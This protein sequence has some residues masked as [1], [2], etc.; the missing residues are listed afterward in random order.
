MKSRV[1]AI[2]FVLSLSQNCLADF[3][4]GVVAFIAG[5][6]ENALSMF[7]PLAETANH[8]YAQYFIGRMYA[9]GQ[10]VD[11][12][13]ELAAKW[14]RKASKLGVADAQYRLGDLYENGDGVPRDI[15]RAYG[16]YSVAAHLGNAKAVTATE[17]AAELLSP[18]EFNAALALSSELIAKYGKTPQETARTQ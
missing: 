16:W 9:A 7:V 14:Y 13:A 15:E 1:S 12:N 8:A 11:K 5:N 18:I 17:R 10:G 6:Y 4:D 3:N 2:L